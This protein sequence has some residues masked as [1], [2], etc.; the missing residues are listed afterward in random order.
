MVKAI[1][2]HAKIKMPSFGG[3][4]VWSCGVLLPLFVLATWLFF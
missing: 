3:Y 4:M 1:A 2:E